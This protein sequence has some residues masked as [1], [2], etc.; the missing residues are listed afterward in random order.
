MQKL[1]SEWNSGGISRKVETE[2]N[3]GETDEAFVARHASLERAALAAWPK[4]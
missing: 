3:S 1:T 4:D 2:R